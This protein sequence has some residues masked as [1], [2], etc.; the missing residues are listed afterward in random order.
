MQLLKIMHTTDHH[1]TKRL[2]RVSHCLI[3]Q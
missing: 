3:T 2:R 1:T